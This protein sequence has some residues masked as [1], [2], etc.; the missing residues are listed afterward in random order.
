MTNAAFTHSAGNP[1][2]STQIKYESALS[3][4]DLFN[5]FTTSFAMAR[6][7]PDSG[8]I[9]AKDMEKLRLLAAKAL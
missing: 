2:T 8:R 9:S 3:L 7:L 4:G 6:T 5:I 1:V